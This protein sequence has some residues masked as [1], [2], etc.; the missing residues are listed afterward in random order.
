MINGDLVS[1]RE[2]DT[3]ISE[4]MDKAGVTG[5]SVAIINDSKISYHRAFGIR[6]KSTG[7]K[8]NE[9]TNF[10]AASFSKTVFAYLVMLLV[11]DGIIDLDKPLQE[12]LDKPLQEYPNYG[13]L[14]GDQILT[15]MSCRRTSR[16]PS[17]SS[18]AR[19]L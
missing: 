15:R 7:V 16:M 5:L 9:E 8:N 3:A 2:L 10:S 6:D 18:R 17:S 19:A 1:F 14:E 4:I 13:D 11:E 12:Y